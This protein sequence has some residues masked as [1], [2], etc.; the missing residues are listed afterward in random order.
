M[1]K[2]RSE[3]NR[4]IILTE[5]DKAALQPSLSKI[6]AACTASDIIGKTINQNLFDIIEFL[7]EGFADLLV[8]DP[9]YNLSKDFAGMKFKATNNDSYTEYIRSWLPKI[10]RCLKPDGSLYVCCDWKSSSAVFQVLDSIAIIK[11]RITWQREK[12]RGAKTNWK[13]PWKIYGSP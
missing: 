10:V 2:P 13:T 6:D 7:P 11:N 8:I 9:P 4:T 12:G 5:A 3:R 1:E